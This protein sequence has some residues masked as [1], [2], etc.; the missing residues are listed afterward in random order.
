LLRQRDRLLWVFEGRDVSH[1]VFDSLIIRHGIGDQSHLKPV[2][3]VSV[4]AANTV[5]EILDLGREI[6]ILEPRQRGRVDSPDT[7]T[8][9]AMA[10][11]TG[12]LI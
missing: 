3:V 12:G 10:L 9:L 5:A 7:L 1:H 4:A 6:P 2:E 11:R 8:E